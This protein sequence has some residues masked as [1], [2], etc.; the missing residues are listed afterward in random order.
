MIV[1]YGQGGFLFHA[2]ESKCIRERYISSTQFAV[3][4]STAARLNAFVC[5]P[6]FIVF[7]TLL[8]SIACQEP[9]KNATP[10]PVEAAEGRAEVVEAEAGRCVQLG[11]TCFP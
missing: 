9:E 7:L 2:S 4:R 6:I 5:E 8:S 3:E 11:P 1:R 10:E